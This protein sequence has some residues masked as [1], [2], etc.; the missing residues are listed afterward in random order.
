MK[1]T[2]IHPIDIEELKRNPK[3]FDPYKIAGVLSE[4]WSEQLGYPVEF[5]LTPKEPGEKT[6]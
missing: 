2:G 4:L 3:P 5:V 1:K 6:G